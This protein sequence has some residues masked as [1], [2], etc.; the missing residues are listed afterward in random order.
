MNCP[1]FVIMSHPDMDPCSTDVLVDLFDF[2]LHSEQDLD[3]LTANMVV[4]E[5]RRI[6]CSTTGED[7]DYWTIPLRRVS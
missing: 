1:Y 3:D 2:G 7:D 5:E 4:G 6:S